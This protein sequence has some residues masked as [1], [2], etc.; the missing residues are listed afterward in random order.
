VLVV[1]VGYSFA[2]SFLLPVFDLLY[3]LLCLLPVISIRIRELPH[4]EIDIPAWVAY[5]ML[6]RN[7]P[8]YREYERIRNKNLALEESSDNCRHLALL[9]LANFLIG[10]FTGKSFA[11]NL[12]IFINSLRGEQRYLCLAP[13]LM[14]VFALGYNALL[15][16]L[17]M[18]VSMRVGEEALLREVRKTIESSEDTA[19]Q[20]PETEEEEC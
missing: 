2:K 16:P 3:F 8:A 6:T 20:E 13:L 7:T 10:I 1:L 4:R 11:S 5:S 19:K 17:S 15:A 12:Y 14:F 18:R 9:L